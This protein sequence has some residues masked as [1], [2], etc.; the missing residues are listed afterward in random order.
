ML[1]A[2][3]A[4]PKV[5]L[6]A[7]AVLVVAVMPLRLQLAKLAIQIQVVAAVVVAAR[8]ATMAATAVRAS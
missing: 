6:Q 4:L 1:V 2:V 7:R 3:G 8:P 5:A